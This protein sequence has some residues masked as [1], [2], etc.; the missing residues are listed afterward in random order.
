M[1][2]LTFILILATAAICFVAGFKLGQSNPPVA[3]T[4]VP[5]VA[6]E[7]EPVIDTAEPIQVTVDTPEPVE[8][9]QNP[10]ELRAQSTIQTFF[11]TTGREL[12]AEILV[13]GKDS[14]KVRRQSDGLELDLSVSMLSPEDQ[15]FAAYLW[16][17][18]GS[19]NLAAPNSS[20]SPFDNTSTS[21]SEED[22]IWE[23]LFQ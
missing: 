6:V 8:V 10:M 15:A 21:Q 2:F 23:E 20:A 17:E 18:Q 14:L 22:K 9:A 3:A 13:V 12:I 11:D 19:Q 5:E 16:K 1:R 7:V 4:P